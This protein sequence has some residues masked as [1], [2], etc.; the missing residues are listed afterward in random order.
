MELKEMI[1]KAQEAFEA[2]SEVDKR[3]H[4]FHQAASFAYGNVRLS[5]ANITKEQARIEVARLY[6]EKD[7]SP[8]DRHWM[9]THKNI[10][11]YR[12]NWVALRGGTLLTYD[13]SRVAVV[14]KLRSW[15]MFDMEVCL[16]Y[17]D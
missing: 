16:V 5:G 13:P 14:A 1:Q 10:P 17:V 2:L 9:D 8:Y 3:E 7:A 15:G 4:R 12:G 6:F 11:V